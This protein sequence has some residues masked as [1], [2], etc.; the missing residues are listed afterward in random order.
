MT[1]SNQ[2]LPQQWRKQV[3]VSCSPP[4]AST[5]PA[6][7]LLPEMRHLSIRSIARCDLQI[8]YVSDRNFKTGAQ[9]VGVEPGF[10]VE[11]LAAAG[12]GEVRLPGQRL[13]HGV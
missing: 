7:L 9:R 8:A 12:E 2:V 10:R 4:H 6:R 11:M 5:N 3:A 1:P 13:A